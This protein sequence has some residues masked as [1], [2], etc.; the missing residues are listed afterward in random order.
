MTKSAI[1]DVVLTGR[2]YR[3]HRY[4]YSSVWWLTAV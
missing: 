3:L 2:S 4:K 1:T